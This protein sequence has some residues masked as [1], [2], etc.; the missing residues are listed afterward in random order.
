MLRR[1]VLLVLVVLSLSLT[2]QSPAWGDEVIDFQPIFDQPFQG[3]S[4][5][6]ADVPRLPEAAENKLR[7]MEMFFR[8][9][10][11]ASW[12]DWIALLELWER[13]SNWRTSAANPNS[14]ARGIPQAM[15]SLYPETQSEEWL[16]DPEA[17]I[18]WGLDYIRRRYG[19]PSAALE[20]HDLKGWY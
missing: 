5:G 9:D 17:Q 20:H 13:E 15:T 14:S 11:D 19:S 4:V 3:Y 7:A 12:N 2:S 6:D 8:N 16:S 18:R 10:P 1:G